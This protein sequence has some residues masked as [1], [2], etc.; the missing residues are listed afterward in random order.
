MIKYTKNCLYI[1]TFNLNVQIILW[2][3]L[4]TLDSRGPMSTS[5]TLILQ[6][7]IPHIIIGN[8]E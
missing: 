3:K 1:Q 8:L 7:S 2:A 5:S 4:G 6:K